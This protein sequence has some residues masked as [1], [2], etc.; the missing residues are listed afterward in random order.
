MVVLVGEINAL[1]VLGIEQL[2]QGLLVVGGHLKILHN[3]HD[4]T[5]QKFVAGGVRGA[6][7]QDS[8]ILAVH[9]GDGHKSHS[10]CGSHKQHGATIPSFT[11]RASQIMCA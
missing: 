2:D 3:H 6:V 10:V 7:D 8:T 9:G 1:P 5:S 4:V 11:I